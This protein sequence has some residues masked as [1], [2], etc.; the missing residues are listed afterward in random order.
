MVIL[1]KIGLRKKMGCASLDKVVMSISM[2]SVELWFV[3]LI[4]LDPGQRCSVG[5]WAILVYL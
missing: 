3:F 1:R 5:S 2:L 4:Y